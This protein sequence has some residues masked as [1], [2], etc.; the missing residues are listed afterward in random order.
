ML[1]RMSPGLSLVQTLAALLCL[2][3][4]PKHTYHGRALLVGVLSSSPLMP[5]APSCQRIDG[6]D[7]A[8]RA[9]RW[10]K[11][12]RTQVINIMT[13]MM[14]MMCFVILLSFWVPLALV[15]PGSARHDSASFSSVLSLPLC[16]LPFRRLLLCIFR[17]FACACVT[18][19]I[20]LWLETATLC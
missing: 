12:L 17:V 11:V 7:T 5:R 14:I 20:A 1:H 13:M 8:I 2:P 15:V 4:G 9:L 18:W 19:L 3:P 6:A 16:L 10:I